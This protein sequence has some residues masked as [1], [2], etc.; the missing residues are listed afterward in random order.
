MSYTP[1]PWKA[2]A[3]NGIVAADGKSVAAISSNSSRNWSVKQANARLISAAPDLLASLEAL[4]R[5]W[6]KPAPEDVINARAAIAK[7]KG[8]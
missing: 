2:T 3:S 4:A 8:E 1:G 5:H 6:D 7:A